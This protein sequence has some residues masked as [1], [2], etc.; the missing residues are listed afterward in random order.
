MRQ[1]DIEV[2]DEHPS[3]VVVTLTRDGTT[4]VDVTLEPDYEVCGSHI[5]RHRE[6]REEIVVP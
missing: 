5:P 2:W 3:V 6:A 4:I 1:Y